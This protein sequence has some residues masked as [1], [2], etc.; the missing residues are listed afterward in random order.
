MAKL[1][2]NAAIRATMS[3][4]AI[5]IWKIAEKLHLHENTVLR[6]LRTEL[7]GPQRIEIESAIEA[8]LAER[9]G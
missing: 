3:N 2:A 5:P 6:R 7:T 8:I 9:R 4:N 1:S